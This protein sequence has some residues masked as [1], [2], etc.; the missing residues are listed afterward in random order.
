MKGSFDC[1]RIVRLTKWKNEL[2]NRMN[3]G[4]YHE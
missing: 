3:K 1:E 4:M 2:M